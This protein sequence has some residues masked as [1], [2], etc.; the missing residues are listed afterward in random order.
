MNSLY[1]SYMSTVEQS[2]SLEQKEEIS[3]TEY[4]GVALK[5]EENSSDTPK[6]QWVTASY[7]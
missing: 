4:A 2:G 1:L 6:T 3:F 7:N 5:S